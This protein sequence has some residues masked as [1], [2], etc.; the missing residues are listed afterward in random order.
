MLG[1]LS[2]GEEAQLLQ[3]IEMFEIITQSDPKDYQ[4][5]EILKEA[6]LKLGRQ[7]DVVSASKRIAEAYVHLGQLS[8][9]ILEYETILQRNPEDADVLAA[10]AEIES[11]AN[12]L[13]GPLSIDT[14]AAKK[15][16]ADAGAKTAAK[17]AAAQQD[18]GR[19]AMKKIFTD[20]K[21]ISA[22]EFDMT[23]AASNTS[24]VLGRII[25][26]FLQILAEKA[27]CPI[28]KA[29]KL[30][31]DKTRL[32]YLPLDRYDVDV[33]LARS[34]PK[35]VCQRWCVMPIDRLSKTVMVA[36][37]NPFNKQAAADLQQATQNRLV[38][39]LASPADLT[40]VLRKVFR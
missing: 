39:Y 24:Q 4:S 22:A 2:Q 29:L 17:A 7:K 1:T 23:W 8:S 18:D 27:L 26:P 9:A 15:D 36:T 20:A 32:G 19:E 13:S 21:I 5:L 30:I 25:E 33:E 12:S 37:T 40:K 35:D 16:S 31:S 38:W 6:Y 34:F 28:D 14:S 10:M 11:K 3:T